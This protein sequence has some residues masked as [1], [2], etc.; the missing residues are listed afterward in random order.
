MLA[1]CMPAGT[2]DHFDR[3][4]FGF[5]GFDFALVSLAATKAIIPVGVKG[6]LFA[7]L[8]GGD[9]FINGDGV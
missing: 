6:N 9:N 7:G 2:L 3:L 5:L 1:D 8:Q 4:L